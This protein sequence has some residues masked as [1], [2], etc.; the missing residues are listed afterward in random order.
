MKLE[1]YSRNIKKQEYSL[2]FTNIEDMDD[3]RH[4]LDLLKDVPDWRIEKTLRLVKASDRKRSLAGWKLMS[5]ILNNN[6]LSHKDLK[7]N[8]RGK[9]SCDS[10]NFS[11][12]HSSDYVIAT[13]SNYEVGCDIEKV[14]NFSLNLLER[15]LTNQ[16]KKYVNDSKDFNERNRRFFKIWTAKEAYL[17]M[18]GEGIIKNL[19]SIEIDINNSTVIRDGKEC[20]C[21]L[22]SLSFKDYELAV[23]IS[24]I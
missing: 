18:T 12:S 1:Y 9:P 20:L 22:E 5:I 14:K 21:Y 17:K 16:E 19:K 11:I 13:V 23:C 2:I 24:K 4:H 8:E 3:P 10:I 7:F 15:I 6:N